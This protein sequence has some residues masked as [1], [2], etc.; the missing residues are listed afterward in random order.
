MCNASWHAA[1]CSSSL[2]VLHPCNGFSEGSATVLTGR[3]GFDDLSGLRS[4]PGTRRYW[5]C[6]WW[7]ITYLMMNGEA[8]PRFSEPTGST[9]GV[10]GNSRFRIG[11]RAQLF[12]R[13]R[14]AERKQ[15]RRN[16]VSRGRG[17]H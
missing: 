2:F 1:S 10:L 15:G 4:G 5:P 11:K 16:E 9:C 14:S 12:E 3:S 7:V 8:N 6:K 17:F 13:L